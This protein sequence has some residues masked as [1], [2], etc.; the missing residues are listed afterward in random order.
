MSTS[1]LRSRSCPSRRSLGP[2][3]RPSSARASST[4]CSTRA[5]Q[6]TSAV[7]WPTPWRKASSLPLEVHLAALAQVVLRH[8]RQI[9]VEDRDAVPLGALLAVAVPVLPALRS[10]HPQIDH[11]IAAGHRTRLRVRAEIADQNHF[12]HAR[13]VA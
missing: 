5:L 2:T 3:K 7:R 13:H 4:S 8:L 11:F 1:P 9:L 12:V 10:R 6:S